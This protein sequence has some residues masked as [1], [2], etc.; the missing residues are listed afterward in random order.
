MRFVI[1]EGERELEALWLW[2]FGRRGMRGSMALSLRL[3]VLSFSY[4]AL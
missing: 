2:C 3:S 4:I 1:R